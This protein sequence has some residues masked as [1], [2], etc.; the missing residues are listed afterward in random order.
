MD[1]YEKEI[2]ELLPA[3]SEKALARMYD[4]YYRYLMQIVFRILQDEGPAQ[5]IVQ[6]VFVEIWR[7]KENLLISTSLKQYLRR[8]AINKSLN[9]IRANRLIVDDNHTER[10]N[11]PNLA[12]EPMLELE[13]TELKDRIAL[14]LESLPARCRLV[15]SLSRF[16]GMTNRQIADNLDIS[17]K[18]VENQ[19]TKALK[20]M[21]EIVFREP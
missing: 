16:E 20:M 21:R 8:A 1:L 17:I 12:A 19:M 18:T 3:D 10:D 5:D 11:H 9:Y 15:F 14:G 13:M 7:K 4:Q 6:A 2:L